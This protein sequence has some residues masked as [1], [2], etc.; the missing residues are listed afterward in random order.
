[1]S[2]PRKKPSSNDSRQEASFLLGL[3]LFR[4]FDLGVAV[5]DQNLVVR[6]WN[7]VLEEY[8]H[9]QGEA[10]GQ[11]WLEL[12]EPFR[13]PDADLMPVVEALQGALM[14]RTVQIQN[15]P[16]IVYPEPRLRRFN[17]VAAPVAS[18]NGR[19]GPLAALILMD[20]SSSRE[21]RAH[22]ERILDSA[23]DGIMVLDPNRRVRIFNRKCGELIGRDPKDV[24]R[25]NC[26]CGEAIGCHNHR[27]QSLSDHGLCPA[28][29]L[30]ENNAKPRAEEMLCTNEGGE[31]RWVETTYSPVKNDKGQ[32]EFVIG[33]MRDIN[34]RKILEER[35][36]QTEKLA[37]LGQLTAG[38]AH[39]IKNPLGIMLASCEI[40]TDPSRPR[41]MQMEAA[42]YI[43][44]EVQ[45]LDAR[46]RSFLAFARPQPLHPEPFVLNGLVRRTLT[47]FQ[48][49]RPQIEISL[50]LESPE[51]IV[52]FDMDQ[53][54]QVLTNLLLNA[55]DAM[56]GQ[57][58]IRLITRSTK[59]GEVFLEV[60]D[61]G[62][63]IP[64]THR[65]RIFDPFFTTKAHGTGLGL[66]ISHRI[67]TAH[68]GAFSVKR[69]RLGGARFIIQLPLAGV[70][71]NNGS[72][73]PM[74]GREA[75]QA[76]D[77]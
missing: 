43:K 27:G 68:G 47:T 63:G 16:L 17:A 34:E 73:L 12:M 41:E 75:E 61:T 66:S 6:E 51:V 20:A 32:V 19:K 69:S 37:A 50:E 22:Y 36:S 38:I 60:H 24:I 54:Q 44:E 8:W 45:R 39:E 15:H 48:A 76:G 64:E 9:P 33:V 3:D 35:L 74:E 59:D 42:Q 13:A 67:I 25:N 77:A 49:A 70:K 62:P 14:G 55:S 29:D 40:L 65:K 21:V 72:G 30:F 71:P 1:M 5:V 58:K 10:V 2:K 46:L 28:V 26:V 23:S 57:G 18:G 56:D 7:A 4:H 11:P 52:H 31:D 53:L